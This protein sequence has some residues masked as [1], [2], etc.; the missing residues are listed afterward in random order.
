MTTPQ[1]DGGNKGRHFVIG[2]CVA[3]FLVHAACNAI[4][5]CAHVPPKG[6]LGGILVGFLI[7]PFSA[8]L[9]ARRAIRG[10]SSGV[11]AVSLGLLVAGSSF[12][13]TTFLLRSSVVNIGAIVAIKAVDLA[14]LIG[15]WFVIEIALPS[16]CGRV[17][18]RSVP[19]S[20]SESKP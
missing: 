10:G 15:I 2:Q 12:Y 4:T 5:I 9:S 8:G 18:G 6:G 20:R 14:L 11:P 17:F 13:P 19:P 3:V 7:M 1:A 16:F